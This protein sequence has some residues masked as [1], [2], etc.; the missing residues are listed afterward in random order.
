MVCLGSYKQIPICST[1]TASTNSH[2]V[3]MHVF[4]HGNEHSKIEL[5]SLGLVWGKSVC[6]NWALVPRLVNQM[7]LA[8][9]VGCH[10]LMKSAASSWQW[11]R[12]LMFQHISSLL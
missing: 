7:L 4:C 5:H 12:L 1:V 9:T 2:C 8:G 6:K 10:C 11:S 3:L